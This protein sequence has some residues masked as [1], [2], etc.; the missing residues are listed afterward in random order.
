MGF[1]YSFWDF[2]ADALVRFSSLLGIIRCSCSCRGPP[3]WGL[4]LGWFKV[5]V[6]LPRAVGG[7][8]LPAPATPCGYEA[9]SVPPRA[10]FRGEKWEND[11]RLAAGAHILIFMPRGCREQP[12]TAPSP[13]QELPGASEL[14]AV[15]P[16][17]LQSS[18]PLRT[19]QEMS[20]LQFLW[21]PICTWIKLH[22]AEFYK[23]LRPGCS[24]WN[25]SNVFSPFPLHMI[26]A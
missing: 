24:L 4:V 20:L 23:V 7:E 12:P 14:T 22:F 18:A 25:T 15:D 16:I 13:M 6:C 8:E 1:H 9:S 5:R 10:Y 21:P 3:R 26:A 2:K 19:C 17:R 11:C